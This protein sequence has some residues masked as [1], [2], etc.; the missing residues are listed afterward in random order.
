MAFLGRLLNR[1]ILSHLVVAVPPAVALGWMVIDINEDAI[2]LETQLLNLSLATQLRDRISARVERSAGALTHAESVLDLEAISIEARQDIL[3]GLVAEGAID[4]LTIHAPSGAFDTSI[5]IREATIDESPLAV[6]TE[7]RLEKERFAVETLTNGDA[8]VVVAWRRDDELLGFL[9]TTLSAK[10]ISDDAEQLARSYLP[11]GGE[12]EVVDSERNYVASSR[13]ERVGKL[14]G[15]DSA[16]QA[17]RLEGGS[18]TQIEAGLSTRF[19][20]SGDTWLASIMSAPKLGWVVGVSRPE[21]VAFISI[22]RVKTR[23]ILMALIAALTAG[24]VG[25]LM[26]RQ[27]TEPISRLVTQVKRAARRGFSEDAK[28]HAKGEL[29]QLASAFNGALDELQDHRKQLRQTTQMRLRLG[30]FVSKGAMHGLL[31]SSETLETEGPPRPIT[32]LYADVVHERHADGSGDEGNEHLVTLLGEFFSAAHEVL[33]SKGGRIDRYSGDAVIGIFNDEGAA[34]HAIEAALAL[35]SDANAIA[36]R[37]SALAHVDLSASVGVV[38]GVAVVARAEATGNEITVS[39]E[40]VDR[41]AAFQH[42]APPGTVWIDTSTKDAANASPTGEA[43]VDD[44]AAFVL[45]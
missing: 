45:G 2:E 9:A 10:R 41:A 32:L 30:R 18:L 35:I 12:V 26:A 37:W 14:A 19:T 8:R 40:I 31:A 20:E 33:T 13:R 34:A 43:Q 4:H 44:E 42:A 25:L 17:V 36:D 11:G 3:R 23:T 16:F 24:V 5:Q 6:P 1:A 15:S 39:G 27:V 7:R 28:V 22:E 29:G 38:S 21:K